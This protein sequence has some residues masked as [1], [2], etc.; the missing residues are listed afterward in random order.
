MNEKYS[1]LLKDTFIFAIGNFGSKII[2]FFLVPLYTNTLTREEYG[3]AD[4]VFTMAQLLVPLV[5]ISIWEGVVRIG[6]KNG[7]KK[8]D[9]LCDSLL[10][11]LFSVVLVIL[12]TPAWSFYRP[13]ANWRYYLSLYALTYILNQ[14]ELNYI[15]IKERNKLF[16][17]TSIIQTLVLATVNILLLVVFKL[18]IKGYLIANITAVFAAD[19]IVALAGGLLADVRAGHINIDLLKQM[20]KYSAPL[21]LNNISWWVIHSSDKFMI[22]A[23]LTEG[24][25][26]LYT[27][28]SKIPSLINVLVS[29]FTQAW[30]LSSI[31]E[32]ESTNDKSFYTKVFESY[33]VVLFVF[34]L[35]FTV[36]VKP[37]MGIYVGKEFTEA[38]RYVPLL[39]YAAVFQAFSAFFGGLLG[40]MQKSMKT[41]TTTIIGGIANVII[42]YIFIRL[43]GVWGALIGT[44]SAYV[45]I[46]IIRAIVVQKDIDLPIDWQRFLINAILCMICVI[47]T[48]LLSIGWLFALLGCIVFVIYNRTVIKELLSMAVNLIKKIKIGNRGKDVQ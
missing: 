17:I 43:V 11:F 2:L 9:V 31:R 19:I 46:L 44:V 3:I 38:W 47:L 48:S 39:F 30:G 29:V 34:M 14:I 4:Y 1:K 20:L 37:F 22:E 21:V 18:G 40:A 15:K 26:G 10:V 23:M 35:L 32:I 12:T 6:L 45:I 36:I 27:V 42:N 8:E 5:S 7:V 24:D 16:A 33:S 13:I 25:L 41:M 28:S